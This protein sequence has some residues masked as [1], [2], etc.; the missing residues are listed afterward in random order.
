MKK[1]T[2]LVLIL[3]LSIS[4]NSA[5][6]NDTITSKLLSFVEDINV[7]SQYLP[8]EKVYLHLDNSNYFIGENIW[9]KAYVVSSH[10]HE[11]TNM[12]TVLYVE[13]LSREGRVLSTNKYKLIDGEC[14]GS[15]YLDP[16]S[17]YSD[18][19]EIRAYTRYMT[20]FD[21]ESIFS[22]VIP[23]YTYPKDAGDY[24]RKMLGNQLS[25]DRQNFREKKEKLDLINISFYPEGGHLV[26]GLTS[27][28][29]FKITD[30]EGKSIEGEGHIYNKKNEKVGS[31]KTAHKGMGVFSI[32]PMDDIYKVEIISGNRNK[33]V[34]LPDILNEG[35][36]LSVNNLRSKS[37]LAKVNLSES[38]TKDPLGL[39]LMVRGK[40][41]EFYIVD[42]SEKNI[43]FNINK[44]N[45]PT[46]VAQLILFNKQGHVLAD[47]QLFIDNNSSLLS[48]D[49][50]ADKQEYKPFEAI[51]L[52]FKITDNNNNPVSTNLSLSVRDNMTS[53]K[54]VNSENLQ[55]SVLLSSEI[56]GMIENPNY[57]FEA[58]D[59]TRKYHL[60]LLMLTQG[61]RR[62]KWEVLTGQE[63]F[64]LVQIPEKA[65]IIDGSIKSM[66][67]QTAK[68]KIEMQLVMT[69]RN[70]TTFKLEDQIFFSAV[71]DSLGKYLFTLP[72]DIE[73]KWEAMILAKDKGKLKDNRIVISR[74][75]PT[76][77]D[78]S[79]LALSFLD[80]LEKKEFVEE[81]TFI[82]EANDSIGMLDKDHALGEI[83]IVGTEVVKR[84]VEEFL[85]ASTID[86]N[87]REEYGKVL[88]S[89]TFPP[90][91]LTT[92]MTKINPSFVRSSGKLYYGA[93]PVHLLINNLTL[94]EIFKEDSAP[95][96]V[97]NLEDM[98]YT[99]IDGL[100]RIVVSTPRSI[101]LN[102]I[103]DNRGFYNSD[104]TINP[105]S[106][107]NP[108][109]VYLFLYTN[110]GDGIIR[111]A[112]GTRMFETEGYT[113]SKEFYSPNYEYEI[114]DSQDEDFRRTIYWDPQIKTDTNGTARVTFYNN[115]SATSLTIN[116]ET[117][118]EAGQVGSLEKVLEE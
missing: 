12:S 17:H 74:F 25:I 104:I 16:R 50:E 79:K 32:M 88:D 64:E 73:G 20:N 66:I 51:N 107:L 30:N 82:E 63:K 93:R 68:E 59:N 101:Q 117:I 115:S 97:T 62:Y 60:D 110:W 56:K 23:V 54:A 100:Y 13:L 75:S 19:Y 14:H 70:P 67:R 71:T 44:E 5:E 109:S 57:Y 53:V 89:G 94:D 26:K 118:S 28:V 1:I 4:L 85:S 77:S 15:I 103:Y 11:K 9:F 92:F 49:I 48:I 34:N 114:E 7:L 35:Y 46:G 95:E 41:Y 39:A 83:E 58:N 90:P 91:D 37:I 86:Y 69:R 29:A 10:L 43:A 3:G 33:K 61:W 98:F 18:F 36:V 38:I 105:P 6:K 78:F 21:K 113:V 76:P 42:P 52:S 72:D 65:L 31:F 87:V 99:D 116:A 55:T 84:Q 111:D 102:T 8:Q 40:V 112:R 24:E 80:P 106:G 2:T 27:Q 96:G 47:R 108:E 81:D 22:R 45:I